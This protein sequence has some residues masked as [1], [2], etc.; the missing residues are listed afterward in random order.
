MPPLLN[1]LISEIASSAVLDT[2]FDWLCECRIDYADSADRPQRDRT[3]L[4]KLLA[5][6]RSDPVV[7]EGRWVKDF[8]SFKLVGKG[9]DSAYDPASGSGGY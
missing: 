2:T 1:P 3:F 9:Q 6:E 5:W 8:G 4:R 7:P